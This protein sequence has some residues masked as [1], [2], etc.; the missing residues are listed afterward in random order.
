MSNFE[1]SL[2]SGPGGGI[3][4]RMGAAYSA[5]RG[6]GQTNAAS[7]GLKFD[8]GGLQSFKRELHSVR[9]EVTALRTSFKD[10]GKGLGSV[11]PEIGYSWYAGI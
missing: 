9:D 5:M 3:G 7:A 2:S 6:R 11:S 1:P 10:I 8:I 4:S